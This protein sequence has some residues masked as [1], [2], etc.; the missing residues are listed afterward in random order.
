M[1]LAAQ[2]QTTH[3]RHLAWIA[4]MEQNFLAYDQ[5]GNPVNPLPPM[6]DMIPAS[7]ATNITQIPRPV[8]TYRVVNVLGPAFQGELDRTMLRMAVSLSSFE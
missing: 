2:N 1:A 7:G 6:A 5:Q 4:L 8:G 3:Q